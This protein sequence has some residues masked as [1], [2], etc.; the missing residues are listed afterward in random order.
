MKLKKLFV[1]GLLA[2]IATV[3]CSVVIVDPSSSTPGTSVD[4][5]ETSSDSSDVTEVTAIKDV[6]DEIMPFGL[7]KGV[8]DDE[9]PCVKDKTFTIEGYVVGYGDGNYALD[10]GQIYVQD[11]NGD[12]IL[13]HS[14]KD[15]DKFSNELYL[16]KKIRATGVSDVY[17]GLP[18]LK[19]FDFEIIDDT[20]ADV[21]SFYTTV[22][23]NEVLDAE[24]LESDLRGEYILGQYKF[25][26]LVVYT[27]PTTSGL[28]T[29]ASLADILEGKPEDEVAKIGVYRFGQIASMYLEPKIKVG[30]VVDL[31][32]SLTA[33]GY[34]E[35]D[36]NSIQLHATRTSETFQAI[37]KKEVSPEVGAKLDAIAIVLQDLVRNNQDSISLPTEG[38]YGSK[39]FWT[40]SHPEVIAVDGNITH[41][42]KPTKVALTAWAC[43][44]DSTESCEGETGAVSKTFRVTVLSE[45]PTDVKTALDTPED[46]YIYFTGIISKAKA[47]S[48]QYKNQDFTVIDF[49][50]TATIDVFRAPTTTPFEVGMEVVVLGIRDS[51]NGV[52]QVAQGAEVTV[53]STGNEVP[54]P[55]VTEILTVKEVL[56]AANGTTVTFKGIIVSVEPYAEQYKNQN[57]IVSDNGVD[58]IY[59]FRAPTE[60]AFEVGMEVIVTGVRSE[61]KGSDQIGS[62][63]EVEVLAEGKAI[64]VTGLELSGPETVKANAAAFLLDVTFTPAYTSERDIVWSIDNEEIA[65]IDA[66]GKITPKA[67][68]TVVVTATSAVNPEVKATFTIEITEA[69]SVELPIE[70]DF[71]ETTGNPV[72]G[73]TYNVDSTPYKDGSLKLSD[74][75]KFVLSPIYDF[76][77][78]LNVELVVKGNNTSTASKGLII[79]LDADGNVLETVEFTLVN[80]KTSTVSGVLPAETVQIKIGY[81]KDE[82]NMG[83]Y[84]IKVTAAE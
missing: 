12:S 16:G 64:P 53:L 5:S 55:P 80:N 46:D 47:Y 72:E 43:P 51:Y 82:G 41:P 10:P 9:N 25:E 58:A 17:N 11:E 8:C 57:F 45:Q 20:I 71:L 65:T 76:S 4:T 35:T 61:Y 18:Q 33:Y 42:N 22:T 83:L 39:I 73:W 26:D 78:S 1:V 31:Y 36:K 68:G 56:E 50:G 40:T 52:P 37:V 34:G 19:G 67:V 59:I 13:L 81:T 49:D 21:A 84:S 29:F 74:S 14:A 2:L 3:G 60:T 66:D 44:A 75:N 48:E 77:T 70:V 38:I 62:S 27:E 23:I 15:L 28:T 69:G 7:G 30:D 24:E 79:A 63:P 6:I 54:E 32:A